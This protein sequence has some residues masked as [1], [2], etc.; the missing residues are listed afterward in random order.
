VAVWLMF[1]WHTVM[2]CVIFISAY[3]RIF[4]VIRRQ[5]R[6]SHRTTQAAGPSTGPEV[7]NRGGHANVDEQSVPT[8]GHP[9]HY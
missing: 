4:S 6:V 5:R 2:P 9:S 3:C 7:E 1:V 8:S